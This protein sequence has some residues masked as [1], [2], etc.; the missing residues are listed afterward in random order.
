MDIHLL[1]SIFSIILILVRIYS[2][3]MLIYFLLS[4]LP[5]ARENALGQFMAKIYEPYLEPFR[6]IIPPIG[7]IDISSIVALIV[8]GLFQRGLATIFNM[9]INALV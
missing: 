2:F 7:M 5:G 4:W 9:I 8:L 6:R 1:N 3:G